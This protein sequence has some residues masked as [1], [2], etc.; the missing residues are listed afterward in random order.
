MSSSDSKDPTV[1]DQLEALVEAAGAE[2]I[3]RVPTRTL[4]VNEAT[5]TLEE[6]VKEVGDLVDPQ[7]H[8]RGRGSRSST[9][10]AM[11]ALFIGPAEQDHANPRV[12]VGLE[13]NDTQESEAPDIEEGDLRPRL[14][15][16]QAA[17]RMTGP[18]RQLDDGIDFWRELETLDRED[19]SE[20]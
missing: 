17:D 13:D 20:D 7:E 4:S 11:D 2:K 3:K 12:L 10:S 5:E 15:G 9:R 6:F 1:E 16:A 14:A 18:V 19:D 8:V